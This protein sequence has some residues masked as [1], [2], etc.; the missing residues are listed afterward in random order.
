MK[1]F[2]LLYIIIAIGFGIAAGY[3]MQTPSEDSNQAILVVALALVFIGI[4]GLIGK[5]IPKSK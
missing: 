2:K 1:S 3:W 4:A 5:Y